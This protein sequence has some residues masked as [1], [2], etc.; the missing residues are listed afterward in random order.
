[1]KRFLL[2][3]AFVVFILQGSSAKASD[4]FAALIGGDQDILILGTIT[5]I[6]G[7]RCTIQV[8]KKFSGSSRSANRQLPLEEVPGI[9]QFCKIDPRGYTNDFTRNKKINVGM[10]LFGSFNR[11]DVGWSSYFVWAVNTFEPEKIRV[12]SEHNTYDY[13]LQ[14]FL[15]SD[16]RIQEFIFDRHN[17]E[18]TYPDG[19]RRM[20]Y[21]SLYA[22][23]P[24][25]LAQTA[26][27]AKD[28]PGNI[29]MLEQERKFVLLIKAI[30]ILEGLASLAAILFFRYRKKWL[31][32]FVLLG[33]GISMWL[34]W[35]HVLK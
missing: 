15:N 26:V 35:F 11:D 1:M 5:E 34:L 22:G 14:A 33:N 18:A 25:Y 24:D 21:S 6:E 28:M 32:P 2:A 7:D 19:V 29:P 30:V 9:L 17:V 10:K 27:A 31:F 3:V 23:Y 20:I 13:A 8:E 4:S 16:G 12:I